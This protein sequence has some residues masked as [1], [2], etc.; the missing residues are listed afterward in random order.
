LTIIPTPAPGLLTWRRIRD[1]SLPPELE[2]PAKA[3]GSA[4]AAGIPEDGVRPGASVAVVVGSRGIHGLDTLVGELLQALRT[5]GAR[6]LLVPAMGSHG[7]GTPERQ[8]AVLA[9]LGI[10]EEAM[11]VPVVSRPEIHE[12]G[13]TPTGLSVWVD[14]AAWQADLV[15]PINRVKPHTAFRGAVES[16]P[17]K[18]LSVGLGK[19]ASA[20][21]AHAAGLE[22]AIP[23]VTEHLLSTGKI[24]FGVAVVENRHGR[25]AEIRL[26]R[27]T[28]WL[29]EEARLLDRARSLSPKLPWET[30][31]VL[32]IE[33]IGKDIS[34][35]GMDLNVVGMERRFPECGA[36]PRIAR[37]VALELS[38]PSH[39]NANGVG[40]ADVV[41]RRLAEGI[42]WPSTYAN[43]RTTGFLDAARLPFVADDE[44]DALRAAFRSLRRRTGDP[45]R[46]VRLANTSTLDSF[47][48]TPALL[49]DL[50]AD[51]ELI[52]G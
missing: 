32:V 42:D 20:E 13:V 38:N 27:P 15:V 43:A 1:R 19:R 47:L 36:L 28:G 31:D 22:R 5:R 23:A 37:I 40:Y 9:S 25:T 48:V 33:T 35:T 8:R 39:G 16:G 29:E 10:H 34:G 51:F 52:R 46:A 3:L 7:G 50:P 4:L 18:L 6:P 41:T 26:L 11:G 30:L 21:A 45:V 2:V 17:S 12:V 44:A 49:E 24:P 14:A